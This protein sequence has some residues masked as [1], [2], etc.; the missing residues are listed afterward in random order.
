MGID[1][2]Y[3]LYQVKDKTLAQI[4]ELA[5]APLC[6]WYGDHSKCN[7]SWCLS[8]K[9]SKDGK[10]DNRRPLFDTTNELERMTVERIRKEQEEFTKVERLIQI[11]HTFST[12]LNESL[13]MRIAEVAPKHKHFSRSK[14][15]Y[16]RVA[17]V[18]ATHNLGIS[19]FVHRLLRLLNITP[20]IVLVSWLTCREL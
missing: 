16:Y 13:N 5:N 8:K 3:W 12:Q 4:E 6:H 17:H 9:I 2:W 11:N 7:E 20:T 10:V 15:I 18:I 19:R 1:I 14:S